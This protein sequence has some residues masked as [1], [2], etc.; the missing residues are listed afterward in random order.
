MCAARVL[1]LGRRPTNNELLKLEEGDR[2]MKTAARPLRTRGNRSDRWVGAWVALAFTGVGVAQTAPSDQTVP[3]RGPASQEESS[4]LSEVIV[5]GSRIRGVAPVGSALVSIDQATIEESGLTDMNAVLDDV[6]SLVNLGVGSHLVG[7]T[8]VQQGFAAGGGNS[9]SIHAL[10]QQATLSLVNGHR[11]WAEGVVSD[12]WDPTNIPVQMV[13]RVEVVMDGTSPIY[14]ADAVAGTIN[15]IMRNPVNTFETTAS[16]NTSP[17]QNGW[18]GTVVFGRTWAEGTSHSGGFI[19]SY[20]HTQEGTLAASHF[21]SLYNDNFTAFGGAPSP[22]F[23]SPGTVLSGG[24]TYAVPFGQNGQT[25]TLSQLGAAGGANRLNS[26]TGVQIIP[27]ETGD[28]YVANFNQ[29]ITDSIQFFGDAMVTNRLF[30]KHGAGSSNDLAVAVPNSNPFSPC[31]P[32]HYA[33]GVVTG[34]AA[35]VAACGAGSLT[36][37][38]DSVNEVGTPYNNGIIRLW[39][40]TAGFHFS[41]PGTWRL[42]AEVTGASKEQDSGTNTLSVPDKATYNFFCDGTVYQCNPRGSIHQVP[43]VENLTGGTVLASFH[44]SQ[45]S[46]DGPLFAL[47]GGVVRLAAGIE[48]DKFLHEQ[49]QPGSDYSVGRNSKSAYLELYIP[50]VGPGNAIPGIHK[51]EVDIAGRSDNYSDT[52]STRNPKIGI[53]WSPIDDLKI[54]ASAGRSFHPAPLMDD[55]SLGPIWRSQPVASAAISPAL[56]PQCTNPALFGP[57]GS[58][59]LVYDEAMGVDAGINGAKL[60][61]ET[62]KSFSVGFD[63]NPTALPGLVTSLNYWGIKYINEVQ[64]PQTAA[65]IAGAI[66]E[67]F[68]NSYVIYNPTFFPQLALN[69]PLAYFEPRPRANLSDPNCAAVVGKRITT[70][71][72]FNQFVQCASDTPVGSAASLAS[73]SVLSGQ[74][75]GSPNDVLAFEYFGQQN[76]GSTHAS[77][78]DISASYSWQTPLGALKV[79]FNGEYITKFDVAVMPDA[80]VVDEINQFGYVL[81]FKG[82]GELSWERGFA[83][84]DLQVNLFVNYD[85]PYKM[86]LN[87]LPPGAPATYANIDARTTLDA[88]IIYNTRSV[89]DSWLGKDIMVT[90]SAQNLAN[91]ATPRVVNGSAGNGV[92]FDP[93]YGWPVGREVQLQIGKKW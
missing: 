47:P 87:L 57:N 80:P 78:L 23:S 29:N 35:L 10:P 66:N 82:R 75:A 18:A 71:A 5:T 17:G 45:L 28:H 51:L 12:L 33:G 16:Y 86:P 89:F 81:K 6:P 67:Q 50:I 46:A 40:G 70:Q 37:D 56:C 55:G 61:P 53:S 20:Q 69:N 54:H 41:L 39:E 9:P 73:G 64:N 62:A 92:T 25:L 88:A 15:Y 38:Y 76:A 49:T 34:P 26:W 63:W 42:T 22:A 83:F 58:T 59:R 2:M 24:V 65:G 4:G 7:G 43:W 52:G 19:A 68:F 36:V 8:V 11:S 74:V 3:A 31:N 84:G 1:V 60:I 85:N 48:Y 30:G 90:L 13:S 44:Y 93:L 72:L 14:G 79:G 27:R 91:S 21:P 77:G 32:S